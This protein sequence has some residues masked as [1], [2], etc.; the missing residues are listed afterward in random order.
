[1]SDRQ[2]SANDAWDSM[3]EAHRVLDVAGVEP[4]RERLVA[5]IGLLVEERDKQQARA[6]AAEQKIVQAERDANTAVADV[7]RYAE[8]AEKA[9]ARV[10]FLETQNRTATGLSKPHREQSIS[11][12]LAAD[13]P[14]DAHAA[15]GVRRKSDSI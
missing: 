12:L 11:R 1:M 2:Q 6:E 8:R 15:Q 7:Q 4:S 9:E 13:H 5:R 14:S 3:N 10:Q